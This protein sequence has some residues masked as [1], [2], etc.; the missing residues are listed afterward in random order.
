[1]QLGDDVED[2]VGVGALRLQLVVRVLADEGLGV[3]GGELGVYFG[4]GFGEWVVVEAGVGGGV[5]QVGV[6]E[7]DVQL[8][9]DDGRAQVLVD[10]FDDDVGV[11]GEF[12]Q[13]ACVTSADVVCVLCVG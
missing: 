4:L 3:E 5:V 12:G 6:G 7:L 10:G 1:M 8:L 2:A 9:V 11:A 13:F